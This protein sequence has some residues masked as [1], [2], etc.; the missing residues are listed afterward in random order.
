MALIN[1]PECKRETSDQAR[2]CPQCGYPIKQG[3]GTTAKKWIVIQAVG[4]FAVG[5]GALVFYST[6][7]MKGIREINLFGIGG[8]L[9][10]LAGICLWLFGSIAAWL[11]HD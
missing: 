1:C 7:F 8:L 5:L 10:V 6:F 2:S 3:V 4:T 11:Q 9:T